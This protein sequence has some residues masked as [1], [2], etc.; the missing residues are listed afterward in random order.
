[1]PPTRNTRNSSRIAAAAAESKIPAPSATKLGVS[2]SSLPIAKSSKLSLPAT[3]KRKDSLTTAAATVP[4]QLVSPVNVKFGGGI[5]PAAESS[6]QSSRS[7][8]LSHYVMW[9]YMSLLKN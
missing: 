4:Q 1:M 7:T 9:A 2:Q 8:L 5:K 3:K 6:S